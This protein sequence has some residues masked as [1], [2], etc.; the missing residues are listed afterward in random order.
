[1]TGASVLLSSSDRELLSVVRRADEEDGGLD[2]TALDD[3]ERS[4]L[5]RL[6]ERGLVEQ[7]EDFWRITGPGCDALGDL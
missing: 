4:A 1:V 3:E 7:R 2:D 6:A 5:A